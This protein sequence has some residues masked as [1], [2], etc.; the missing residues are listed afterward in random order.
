[1]FAEKCNFVVKILYILRYAKSHCGLLWFG[2]IVLFSNVY[3][4]K[5]VKYILQNVSRLYNLKTKGVSQNKRKSGFKFKSIKII[6]STLV[7]LT[8]T[9]Q[10]LYRLSN[11][12]VD[13]NDI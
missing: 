8:R 12:L 5:R 9:R 4:E 3:Y 11:T 7:V 10:T 1:M 13:F 2:L 6:W